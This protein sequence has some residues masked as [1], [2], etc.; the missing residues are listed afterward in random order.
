MHKIQMIKLPTNEKK[1]EPQTTW[2]DE[3]KEAETAH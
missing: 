3:I 1:N 2:I